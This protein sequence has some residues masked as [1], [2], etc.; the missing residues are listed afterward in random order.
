MAGL[1][2]IDLNLPVL[3]L[4]LS[5]LNLLLQFTTLSIPCMGLFL[6]LVL[7]G[8]CVRWSGRVV[9]TGR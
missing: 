2:V 4:L 5:T 6:A 3:Q 8:L 9:V 1:Q 7:E